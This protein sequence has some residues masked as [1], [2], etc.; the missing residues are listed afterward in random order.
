MR[1]PVDGTVLALAE[2]AGVEID[3]C[4]DCRGIWLDRGELDRILERSSAVPADERPGEYRRR[5]EHDRHHDD[6]RERHHDHDH[7]RRGHTDDRYAPPA[8][9]RGSAFQALT[10]LLGGG[11]D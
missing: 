9:K 3:Y 1:C 2:R 10:G 11:E 5:E 7:D 8:R 4:P 6:D